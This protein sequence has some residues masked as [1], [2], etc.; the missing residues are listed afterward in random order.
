MRVGPT[1]CDPS[2]CKWLFC[3]CCNDVVQ[4][5]NP[6]T[7]ICIKKKYNYFLKIKIKGG[8]AALLVCMRI[9][10]IEIKKKIKRMENIIV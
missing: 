6:I 4:E 7:N 2:S 5:S 10:N 1:H 9:E 8:S 3:S